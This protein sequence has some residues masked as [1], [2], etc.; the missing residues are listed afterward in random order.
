MTWVHKTTT[1]IIQCVFIKTGRNLSLWSS[2]SLDSSWYYS[3]HFCMIFECLHCD[4]LLFMDSIFFFHSKSTF[5]RIT[6]NIFLFKK[7]EYLINVLNTTIF[8]EMNCNFLTFLF[9]CKLQNFIYV[10]KI[11]DVM[12]VPNR[13]KK[14]VLIFKSE[15]IHICEV[16]LSFGT[17]RCS[18]T[19]SCSHTSQVVF[20]F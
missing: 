17:S 16:Y 2:L 11:Q 10:I 8:V 4:L 19:S 7:F 6:P 15:N 20:S 1:L 5:V 14:N 3:S 18:S 13:N 9:W 12:K